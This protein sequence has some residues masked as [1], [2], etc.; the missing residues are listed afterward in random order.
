MDAVDC[1]CRLFA[2]SS[3]HYCT[4][5]SFNKENLQFISGFYR[6]SS[7]LIQC[8][9]HAALDFEKAIDLE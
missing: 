1:Y 4:N 5:L 2:H 6:T 8:F 7:K 9:S 3:E